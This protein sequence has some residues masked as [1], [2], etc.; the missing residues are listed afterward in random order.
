MVI[1][2]HYP[3]YGT[4]H[5]RRL[6][7]YIL[8]P[9]KTNQF[10]LLSDYGMNH[11]LD[12]P[13]WEDLV[14]MY[15]SNCLNNDK[16]YERRGQYV[17]HLKKNIH[18][19]H[20]IQSF[21]S[22]DSLSPEEI[23]RIGHEVAMELTGGQ[24]KFIVTTHIDRSHVHNHIMINAIDQNSFKKFVWNK[25]MYQNFKHISDRISKI[26]G[27]K[28]IELN[29]YSH[30][31]FEAYKRSNWGYELKQRL[32][33]LMENSKNYEDF[34]EK[35]KALH[36]KMDFS[37]KHATFF[38]TDSEM[39][40]VIRGNKLNKR[41]PYS[42]DYFQHYFAKKEI[43]QILEYLLPR[44]E[45]F[46]ELQEKAKELH[47]EIKPK[48][49]YVDFVWQ[50]IMISNQA[51]S[52]KE[53]YDLDYFE[54]YF[55]D[56]GTRVPLSEQWISDFFLHQKDE[57]ENV[58]SLDN[59]GSAFQEFKAKRDGVHEFEVT[60]ADHQIEK[61]V[62]DGI[63]I[64]VGYGIGKEGLVFIQNRQLDIIE[65]DRETQYRI[66][67][68]ETAQFFLYNKEKSDLNRFIRGRELI[69]QLGEE[70][71]LIPKQRK[72]SLETIKEKLEE[73]NLLVELNV[74]E[75]SYI[76]IKDELVLEIA[77]LDLAISETNQ[78]IAT[79]T[80]IA[81]CLVNLESEDSESRRLVRYDYGR[82]NLSAAIKLDKVEKEISDHQGDLEMKIDAYEH[83]VRRLERFI[84][85]LNDRVRD[86]WNK[87]KKE[88][89]N[90]ANLQ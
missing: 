37:G 24:F 50:G 14:E 87:D 51:L 43:E 47:L 44:V 62:Q 23:H 6:I 20:L 46:E 39:K 78:K 52:K 67:L 42:K 66:Y 76:D 59:I 29:R 83:S 79:L 4:K 12:F 84:A 45:S 3:I 19:H 90:F 73:V 77:T 82:L 75:K 35:A 60:L 81:E 58:T 68:R 64:K 18:A 56:M 40:Q 80:K 70:S 25:K 11:Y 27:A 21:S 86:S 63:F 31:Q 10:K 34:L 74:Q 85:I 55:S 15:H 38:M 72:A 16:L 61:V 32:Y 48:Q 36:I 49:K 89:R 22:D 54:T 17:E 7:K 69:R 1:T 9:D 28:I 30:T 33:F 71:Q 2:K 88:V 53:M 26:A 8:N 5:R 65:K 13:I 41:Q 57:N